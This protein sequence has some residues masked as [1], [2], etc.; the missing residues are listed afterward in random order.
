MTEDRKRDFFNAVQPKLT[1]FGISLQEQDGLTVAEVGDALMSAAVAISVGAT[2]RAATAAA[3][4]GIARAVMEGRYDGAAGRHG[5][6]GQGP[7]P[8]FQVRAIPGTK[9]NCQLNVQSAIRRAN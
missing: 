3:L 1:Q 8:D 6:C 2:G 7:V 4:L 5:P 9:Q